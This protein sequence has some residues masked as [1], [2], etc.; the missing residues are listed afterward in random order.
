M[1]I[2]NCQACLDCALKLIAAVN[3]GGYKTA[4]FTAGGVGFCDECGKCTNLLKCEASAFVTM[5]PE[6]EEAYAEAKGCWT[7]ADAAEAEGK[8]AEAMEW[9]RE[10]PSRYALE[11][12]ARRAREV[13]NLCPI[14]GG[15]ADAVEVLVETLLTARRQL[16]GFST[17]QLLGRKEAV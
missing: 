6:I 3:E 12:A 15:W 1:K 8:A 11:S 14:W 13:R 16:P 2:F 17:D 4:S 9:L 5:L 10:R 7:C